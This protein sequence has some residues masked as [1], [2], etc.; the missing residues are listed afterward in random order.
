VAIKAIEFHFANQIGFVP[1]ATTIHE[2]ITNGNLEIPIEMVR[3][4]Y[5]YFIDNYLHYLSDEDQEYILKRLS[6]SNQN[7]EA[8][9]WSKNNYPG[10]MEK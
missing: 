8:P 2:R 1:L 6:I 5:K 10:L 3:G 4:D 9:G 7:S